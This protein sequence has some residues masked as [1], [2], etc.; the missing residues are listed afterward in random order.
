MRHEDHT[1]RHDAEKLDAAAAAVPEF[2]EEMTEA[3]GLCRDCVAHLSILLL[4]RLLVRGAD[5]MPEALETLLKDIAGACGANL[6]VEE[7]IIAPR[8]PLQ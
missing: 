6:H 1:A 3:L 5:D 4:G 8:G 7:R 2:I